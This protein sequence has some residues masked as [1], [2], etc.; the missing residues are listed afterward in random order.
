MAV[1]RSASRR[2]VADDHADFAE[3][4]TSSAA[5]LLAITADARPHSR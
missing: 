3:T 4:L 1:M 2:W 5:D